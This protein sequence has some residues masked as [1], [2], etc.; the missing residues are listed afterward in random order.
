MTRKHKHHAYL[1]VFVF[2]DH[3]V[4]RNAGHR[5]A[6]RQSACFTLRVVWLPGLEQNVAKT[7][8]DIV[9]RQLIWHSPQ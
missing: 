8:E 4:T 9:A 7:V 1:E 6:S 2:P 3:Y 5:P